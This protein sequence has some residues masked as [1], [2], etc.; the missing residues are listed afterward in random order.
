VS[1]RAQRVIQLAIGQ[2]PG[3]G[4]D[5]GT[6]KLQHQTPVEIELQCALARFTRRVRHCRPAWSPT[7]YSILTHNRR[8]C[9]QNARLIGGMRAH[10]NIVDIVDPG[11]PASDAAID[12]ADQK[13]RATKIFPDNSI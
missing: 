5:R 3:I 4:G 10:I 6:T 7:N 11:F 12:F 2:Q 8:K 1:V 13:K 9:A